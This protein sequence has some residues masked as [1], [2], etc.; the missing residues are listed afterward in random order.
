MEPALPS[1]LDGSCGLEF[2]A[3]IVAHSLSGDVLVP[4][5]RDVSLGVAVLGCQPHAWDTPGHHGLVRAVRLLGLPFWGDGHET[6]S[7]T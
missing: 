6:N 7:S 3:A 5:P 4:R 2:L 1:P